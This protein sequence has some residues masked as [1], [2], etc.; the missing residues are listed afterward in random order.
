MPV[1]VRLV[2]PCRELTGYDIFAAFGAAALGAARFFPFDRLNLHLCTFR[3]L[4]GIPCPSCGMT[5]C[6]VHLAH[7]RWI[8][9][10]TASPLGTV[11]FMASVVGVLH[12]AGMRLKWLPAVEVSCSKRERWGT[13]ILAALTVG[14]NWAY[15]LAHLR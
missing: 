10:V 2:A 6:F 12:V 5:T 1:K 13:W 14:A 8:D 7:G 11:L 9:G 3:A 4:T 15:N